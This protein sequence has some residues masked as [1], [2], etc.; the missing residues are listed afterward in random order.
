MVRLFNFEMFVIAGLPLPHEHP[1]EEIHCEQVR[2][3]RIFVIMLLCALVHE[4]APQNLDIGT[5][6]GEEGS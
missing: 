6:S 3:V 2:Q 4:P 5:I 1:S